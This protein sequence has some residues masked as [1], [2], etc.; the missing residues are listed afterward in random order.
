MLNYQQE[1]RRLTFKKKVK[2]KK[3]EKKKGCGEVTYLVAVDNQRDDAADN[4]AQGLEVE[5]SGHKGASFSLFRVGHRDVA[6]G[7]VDESSR[8]LEQTLTRKFRA[9]ER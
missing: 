4:G 1:N 3:K 5:R 7:Y 8:G 6:L 9:T 2:K